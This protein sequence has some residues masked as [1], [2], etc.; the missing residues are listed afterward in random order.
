MT[1]YCLCGE[2]AFTIYKSTFTKSDEKFDYGEKRLL[3]KCARPREE[4]MFYNSKK[5]NC[6]YEEEILIDKFKIE[7]KQLVPTSEKKTKKRYNYF[8]KKDLFKLIENYNSYAIYS[9]NYFSKLNYYLHLFNYEQH[10]PCNETLDELKYRVYNNIKKGKNKLYINNDLYDPNLDINKDESEIFLK[11]LKG[12]KVDD[13]LEWAKSDLVKELL[14]RKQKIRPI[15]E[16]GKVNKS[17]KNKNRKKTVE[18][19]YDD[20]DD[21][22]LEEKEEK[23]EEEKSDNEENS[24]SDS[25][26]EENKDENNFD[27]EN[28][29]DDDELDD[30]NVDDYDDFSD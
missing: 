12:E 14:N 27:M 18:K 4:S 8:Y 20:D 15:D 17:V 10:A 5:K 1:H 28:G 9:K 6:D 26:S 7:R 24:D 23:E 13:P 19:I 29:D 30:N 25:E 3:I 2:L 11:I 16:I 21:E 22:D